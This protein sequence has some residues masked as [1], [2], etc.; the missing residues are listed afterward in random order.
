MEICLLR[1]RGP[2][3]ILELRVLPRLTVLYDAWHHDI[4]RWCRS[5]RPPTV[6]YCY[7]CW[8]STEAHQSQYSA[9]HY[10]DVQI[11]GQRLYVVKD[12]DSDIHFLFL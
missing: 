11:C 9:A 6:Q 5:L 8:V 3:C 2:F 4:V 12:N 1:D 7:D 10:S